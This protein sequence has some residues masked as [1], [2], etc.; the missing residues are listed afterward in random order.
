MTIEEV[1][2]KDYSRNPKIAA[3]LKDYGYVKEYGEGV[4]RMCRELEA[5]GLPDP[6]FNNDTFILKTTVRSS[7]Y[8]KLPIQPKSCRLKKQKL[9]V[10]FKRGMITSGTCRL[11]P[12]LR[13]IRIKDIMSQPLYI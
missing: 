1:L 4:D 6:V 11:K 10:Q 12:L 5:A 8:Q 13:H 7:A 2:S 3:L 9:P